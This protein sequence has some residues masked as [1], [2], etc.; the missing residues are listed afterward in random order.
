M[1]RTRGLYSRKHHVSLVALHGGISKIDSQSDRKKR[2]LKSCR[3]AF[4]LHVRYN[5]ISKYQTCLDQMRSDKNICYPH[6]FFWSV[7]IF[8]ELFNFI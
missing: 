8:F 4:I 3:Q 5:N 2:L 1:S 6:S 7:F